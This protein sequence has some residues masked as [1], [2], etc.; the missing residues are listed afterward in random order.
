MNVLLITHSYWPDV[1]PRATRWT[2]VS[3]EFARRG[4]DVTV[5]AATSPE[6]GSF[7]IRNGVK[8]HRVG[9]GLVESMRTKLSGKMK[10]SD[11][12][13]TLRSST[14][15]KKKL[16]GFVRNALKRLHDTFWKSLYWP[17]HTALWCRPATKKTCEVLNSEEFDVLISSSF[18]FSGHWVGHNVKK[19]FANLPWVIDVG[20]PFTF[21]EHTPPNNYRLYR[22]KNDRLERM[23]YKEADA[24]SV[25]TEG[26]LE[27]YVDRYPECESKI[28][29]IP[30]LAPD[31]TNTAKTRNNEN[32]RLQLVYLGTLYKNIRSPKPV[33][34][35]FRQ[36]QQR[37]L[38]KEIELHFYGIYKSCLEDFEP[39]S[40]LVGEKIHLHG[41]VSYREASTAMRN[42]D[43][44]VNIGNRTSFQLPSKVVEYAATGK[45]VL[46]FASIEGDSSEVFLSRY[47]NAFLVNPFAMQKDET[48]LLD[49]L[50]SFLNEASDL[51][52]TTIR[53]WCRPYYVESLADRY[54]ELIEQAIESKKPKSLPFSRAA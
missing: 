46:N 52:E 51:G 32:G 21:L 38:Q 19:K 29:V 23:I 6:A 5:V 14:S 44:L 18:P 36:L 33:L 9:S 20:D 26:T 31:V 54:L 48:K 7:A 4:I 10:T 43:V 25:T 12:G 22:K 17:D 39:Y 47:P 8:I 49:D 1:S 45:P 35:L 11:V 53:E 30:P 37:P 24:I 28:R 34:E 13:S 40:N 16:K 3:E 50:Q 15:L 27:K 42:A 41:Q 2:A